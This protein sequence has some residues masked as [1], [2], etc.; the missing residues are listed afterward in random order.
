MIEAVAVSAA[1]RRA[2]IASGSRMA[3]TSVQAKRGGAEGLEPL[4]PTLPGRCSAMMAELQH[5]H[6]RER[7]STP[8]GS[9]LCPGDDP[10]IWHGSGTLGF[11]AS[12][13]ANDPAKICHA[14]RD[15]ATRLNTR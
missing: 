14:R 11:P 9:L 1:V 15:L 6:Q 2:R 7:A 10:L 5:V 12:Q 3:W 13:P 4:T 8:R